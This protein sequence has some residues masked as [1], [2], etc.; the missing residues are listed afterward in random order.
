MGFCTS[1]VEFWN[2][3]I[4]VTVGS[5]VLLSDVIIVGFSDVAL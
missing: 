4:V 3:L 2:S 5:E 1:N